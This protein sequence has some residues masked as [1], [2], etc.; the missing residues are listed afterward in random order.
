MATQP[1]H[2]PPSRDPADDGTIMGMVKL[3]LQKHLQ[4]VDDMLPARVVSYDRQANRAQV[5]PLVRVLTTDGRQ[6]GRAGV[7]RVPVFRF[8]AGGMVLSFKLKP[9]DFGWL[10]ANDRDISL[11]MQGGGGENAPN[12]VRLHSFQDAMFYPDKAFDVV[13]DG[14][15]EDNA[16]LQTEDGTVRIALWP[17]KVKISTPTSTV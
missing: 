17:D 13:I 4:G 12:T 8:G 3:I 6:I 11:V 16:V 7:A 14:E 10:K 5:V 15:D 2:A 9:G 1:P